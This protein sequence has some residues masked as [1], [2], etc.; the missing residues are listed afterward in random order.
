MPVFYPLHKDLSEFVK[1]P[2]TGFANGNFG[3]W[4]NKMIPICHDN[5]DKK[6]LAACDATGNKDNRTTYYKSMYD[7]MRKSQQI[8]KCLETKHCMQMYYA[9][10]MEKQGLIPLSFKGTLETALIT[11]LGEA[12]PGETSLV[13]DHTMGIPFIPAS[14]VKGM[15]RFA[16]SKN[17]LMDDNG[18][19][20][21]K[22]VIEEKNKKDELIQVLDEKN[23]KTQIP[24]FFGGDRKKES[25]S[26]ESDRRKDT[27]KGKIIF[28]DAY[29][30]SVPDLH[31]DIINPHYSKYYGDDND[32]P[33]DWQDPVPVKFLTVAPE[34]EFVFRF[35]LDS[36]AEQYKNLFIK[37]VKNALEQ[38][39]IGAKTALG[40]GRFISLSENIP[41]SLKTIYDNFQDSI[42]TE[43]EKQENKINKLIIKIEKIV[44]G[45]TSAIDSLFHKWQS[46]DSM[47]DNKNIAKA[48]LQKIKKKKANGNLNNHYKTIAQILELDKKI[49]KTVK[50]TEKI[51]RPVSH[52]K[53]K[54]KGKDKDKDKQKL[55]KIIYRGCCTKREKNKLIKKYKETYPELCFQIK[56]LPDKKK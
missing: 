15:V 12:H 32:A 40:Y 54:D 53:N 33:G 22:F 4:Y 11:G 18:N 31:E 8:K 10:C 28:L 38:E 51:T 27:V 35:L 9:D 20:T 48:F 46:E 34:T 24:L 26:N 3:L 39:G 52:S 56:H 44:K 7:T 36:T 29:P 50:D 14:G 42:L 43:E 49:E 21:D 47:K 30:V 25:T 23:Q 6:N 5:S 55:E 19:F 2:Q 13:L 1:K 41:Q 16:H 45:N 17:L 37:A